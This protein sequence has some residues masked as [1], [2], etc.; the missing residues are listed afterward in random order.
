MVS[1]LL[2]RQNESAIGSG[3]GGLGQ[4]KTIVVRPKQVL[5]WMVVGG[6]AWIA[7]YALVQFF[8]SNDLIA[9]LV[10]ICLIGCVSFGWWLLDPSSSI[11][12]KSAK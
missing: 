9:W 10:M 6:F 4:M 8:T 3:K 1:G 12:A 2:L 7:L 5:F 11:K